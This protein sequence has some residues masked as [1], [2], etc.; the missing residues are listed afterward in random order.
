MVF[1]KVLLPF[2]ME[3]LDKGYTNVLKRIFYPNTSRIPLPQIWKISWMM[4]RNNID[5]SINF[6]IYMV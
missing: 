2:T 5:S 4:D 6:A 3:A 1:E